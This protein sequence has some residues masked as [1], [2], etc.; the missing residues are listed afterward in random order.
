MVRTTRKEEKE[1]KKERKEEERNLIQLYEET[2]E[3]FTGG[4]RTL[5]TLLTVAP[6]TRTS[7]ASFGR[8]CICTRN[9]VFILLEESLSASLRARKKQ[10]ESTRDV[11]VERKLHVWHP[12]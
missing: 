5:G 3:W 6:S 11:L 8:P 7:P 1:R 10:K 9:S 4:V 12:A 2:L